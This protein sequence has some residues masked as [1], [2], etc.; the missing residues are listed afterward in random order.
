MIQL[1]DITK[2]YGSK[3]I[4]NGV[5]EKIETGEFFVILGPSG[6]GKS[7]L[8][9]VFA[10][11]EKLDK[12]KII[13]DGKDI[14]NLPPEKRNVAMV[15]QNYAL[16]PNMSVYD[17][18]AFPLKVRRLSKNKIDEKVRNVAKLLGISDI[19]NMNVTK[20]S[21]GQ[22][23]RVAIA[24]AIV[25][26]PSF[27][28]LDEPLSNLDARVRFVARGELKRIQKELNGTFIYVTHDQ[29]EAMSL[30]DRVAVLHNGNFEQVGKPMDLYEFPKTRWIGEFIG[31]FPMNF[32]P[33]KE[34]GLEEGIEIGFRPE[35]IKEGGELKG[36]VESV[37]VLGENVYAFCTVK[38]YRITILVRKTVD[39][40]DEITFGVTKFRKF[41]DGKLLE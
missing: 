40:G 20:I 28:L 31:D 16:Y 27:Y 9:K 22:Q 14:T 15:F 41:R 11:I 12:G 38:D 10:G 29:K 24:R 13:V 19:L 21:G 35:W 2:R 33:G 5:T 25:R 17:N 4:L 32:L 37:E 1:D 6:A 34:L 7:T 23:Q 26:E 8:L 39:V 36:T 3:V 30:A 18:I